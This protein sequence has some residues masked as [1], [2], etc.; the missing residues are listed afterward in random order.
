MAVRIRLTRAG[1]RNRPFFRVVV[2]DKRAARDGKFIEKIGT[3]N[4]L[5][6]KNDPN[7]FAIDK[8][9]VEYWLSKGA[10]PTEAIIKYLN[11]AG[12]GQQNSYIQAANENRTKRIALKKKQ[13]EAEQKAQAAAKAAEEKAAEEKAKPAA[14]AA[15]PAPEAPAEE[16]PAE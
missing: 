13:W 6:A 8:A 3:Y 9:R 2:A 12:I 16:K 4:P 15:A 10:Q 5:L 11:K 14:E 1:A 7:R